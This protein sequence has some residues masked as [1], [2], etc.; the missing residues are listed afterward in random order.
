MAGRAGP[1]GARLIAAANDAFV[2]AM[3]WAAVVSALV[4]V[5]GVI[6]VLVWLPRR[7][8]TA[9]NPP[10]ISTVDR[11]ASTVDPTAGPAAGRPLVF[12]RTL[13]VTRRG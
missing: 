13:T 7:S 8:A 6:V 12:N 4:A 5:L 11:G 2:T 9:G 3:H 1:V 10:E